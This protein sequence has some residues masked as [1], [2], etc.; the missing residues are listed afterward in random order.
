MWSRFAAPKY[1]AA[2]RKFA[3]KRAPTTVLTEWA[4]N[5]PCTPAWTANLFHSRRR[6]RRESLVDL[7]VALSSKHEASFFAAD[8]SVNGGIVVAGLGALTLLR[9]AA[10]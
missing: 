3:R 5:G 9:V 8:P 10:N 6:C 7:T 1:D 2:D 4:V